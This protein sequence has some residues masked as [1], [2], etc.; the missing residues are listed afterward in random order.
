MI[1]GPGSPINL[2]EEIEREDPLLIPTIQ[3]IFQAN[4][5]QQKQIQLLRAAVFGP[6]SLGDPQNL[7][8]KFPELPGIKSHIFLVLFLFSLN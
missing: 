7:G 1:Y 4:I 2:Q 3:T 5:S 8:C 6:S